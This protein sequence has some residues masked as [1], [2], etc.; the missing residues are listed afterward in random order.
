MSIVAAP[1]RQVN[2]RHINTAIEQWL[3]IHF[4]DTSFNGRVVIGHRKNGGGIYT[5]TARPLT[6]LKSYV[7]MIHVSNHLDYY[8]TANTVS[9]VTRRESGLFGLQ[10]IV[11]DIDCHD[12]SKI[13]YVSELVQSFIWRAKRDLWDT[14]TIPMPNSIVRSGRGVQLWWALVPCYGGSDYGT[15]RYHYDKIKN[16]FMD[17]IECL[18]SEYSD[19]LAGLEV[20]RGASSNPVGYFRLPCTYNTKAKKYGSLE[21]LHTERYDQR[22]LTLLD[23]PDLGEEETISTAKVIPLLSSDIPV[24]KNF[25]ST[26]AKRVIQLINLRNLRSNN[27]G[28]ETR[29]NFNFAVYNA[30]RMTYGHEDAM[31]RLRSYNAGFNQ[32]M[33]EDEL[34]NCVVTAQKLGGYKYTNEKLIE[35]LDVTPEEQAAIGLY[36][37]A[38]KYRP[39]NYSKPNASRDATRKA[40]KNDRD[41]KIVTMVKSGLSQAEVARQLGIGKNTVGRVM[42]KHNDTPTPVVAEI[43]PQEECHHFGSIYVLNTMSPVVDKPAPGDFLVIPF[44]GS[45]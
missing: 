22:E 29:N 24:L 20:D 33:T 5:M 34:E 8:I 42:K 43:S 44:R 6:E 38:G 10:N 19:D 21:I 2:H 26:G 18:L 23:P 25:H 17:H 39:W 11:I 1:I 12:D 4:G 37:F 14:N 30:L 9:G 28:A 36:P 45:P 15:S 41:T 31:V 13:R 7:R 40:L 16:N 3:D 35:L 27:V 32:P